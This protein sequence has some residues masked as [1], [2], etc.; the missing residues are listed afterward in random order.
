DDLKARGDDE[1]SE[2]DSCDSEEQQMAFDHRQT[3]KDYAGPKVKARQLAAKSY[4]S[5]LR[6]PERGWRRHAKDT[7]GFSFLQN[8]LQPSKSAPSLLRAEDE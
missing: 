5:G 7:L 2:N 8:F 1:K 4:L 3:D 6:S